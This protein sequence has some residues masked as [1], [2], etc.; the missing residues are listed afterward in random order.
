MFV[1]VID[2]ISSTTSLRNSPVPAI[3]A[4]PATAPVQIPRFEHL[5]NLYQSKFRLTSV[6]IQY[7]TK[8]IQTHMACRCLCLCHFDHFHR[9]W[10][11]CTWMPQSFSK[12]KNYTKCLQP[13]RFCKL[14]VHLAKYDK[15][16]WKKVLF[17]QRQSEKDYQVTMSRHQ[18]CAGHSPN[19]WQRR[20]SLKPSCKETGSIGCM[21]GQCHSCFPWDCYITVIWYLQTTQVQVPQRAFGR[22]NLPKHKAPK[23]PAYGGAR[24]QKNCRRRGESDWTIQVTSVVRGVW[25]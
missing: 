9:L 25:K 16:R 21:I 24:R 4:L 6:G 11:H 19:Q 2:L 10:V 7:L 1:N 3:K 22:R 17:Q 5:I 15:P 23:T 13:W 12:L 20:T 14:W 18:C 8:H